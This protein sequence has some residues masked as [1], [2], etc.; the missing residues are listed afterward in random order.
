MAQGTNEIRIKSKRAANDGGRLHRKTNAFANDGEHLLKQRRTKT[1]S[2]VP[3]K[4]VIKSASDTIKDS[5]NTGMC[6]DARYTYAET[7]VRKL[8]KVKVESVNNG[9]VCIAT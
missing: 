3:V 9:M 1:A 7:S 5:K 4:N 8:M 6:V 2:K